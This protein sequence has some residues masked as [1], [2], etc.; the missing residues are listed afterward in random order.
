MTKEIKKLITSNGMLV[1]PACDGEGEVGYFAG[2]E[3]TINCSM[4]G[5]HG[6]IA[7]QS[8]ETENK[9]GSNDII[10][11]TIKIKNFLI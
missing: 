3:T 2:H 1:C 6:M 5:G 7:A 10:P 4:C 9:E 8:K 11:W